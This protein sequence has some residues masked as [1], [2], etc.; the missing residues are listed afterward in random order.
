[1]SWCNILNVRV[2]SNRIDIPYPNRSS[3]WSSI[4]SI[5]SRTTLA[6]W[7]SMM[8]CVVSWNVFVMMCPLEPETVSDPEARSIEGTGPVV[9]HLPYLALSVLIYTRTRFLTHTDGQSQLWDLNT[10]FTFRLPFNFSWAYIMS[11]GIGNRLK[12]VIIGFLH[13][14]DVS[15]VERVSEP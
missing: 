11:S 3:I 10:G 13:T 15:N 7:S 8:P 1:M 9:M 6:N 4:Q 5:H 2:R 14:F 12:L